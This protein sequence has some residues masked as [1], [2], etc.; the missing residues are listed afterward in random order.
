MNHK[1]S[2]LKHNNLKLQRS[3][4]F[5]ILNSVAARPLETTFNDRDPLDRTTTTTRRRYRRRSTYSRNL[6][7]HVNTK[8]YKND[9]YIYIYVAVVDLNVLIKKMYRIL[10]NSIFHIIYVNGSD[11][12]KH[13]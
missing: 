9:T 10:R 7:I 3:Y 8:I 11:R 5:S 13:L 6:S 4:L 12:F 1:L 2:A